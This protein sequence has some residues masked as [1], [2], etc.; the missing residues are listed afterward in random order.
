MGGGVGR[1]WMDRV[2]DRDYA[3][4]STDHRTKRCIPP[5]KKYHRL[6]IWNTRY[7]L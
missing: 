1:G 3:A 5:R 4:F 6:I 2:L 7:E